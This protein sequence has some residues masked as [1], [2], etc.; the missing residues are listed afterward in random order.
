MYLIVCEI[1]NV[2]P[3]KNRYLD[4]LTYDGAQGVVDLKT[5]EKALEMKDVQVN[6]MIFR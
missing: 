3:E 2:I 1:L 4:A 6:K 5:Q